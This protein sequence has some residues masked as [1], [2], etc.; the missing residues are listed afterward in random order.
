MSF[1]YEY[2]N[3]EIKK[4]VN[5][6]VD[7]GTGYLKVTD[8]GGTF[9]IYYEGRLHLKHRGITREVYKSHSTVKEIFIK[10]IYRYYN[11]E[12]NGHSYW[13]DRGRWKRRPME[14]KFE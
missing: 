1:G 12:Y 3:P 2:C 7:N 8:F 13:F 10:R 9:W 11:L 6:V 4:W 14:F 5:E